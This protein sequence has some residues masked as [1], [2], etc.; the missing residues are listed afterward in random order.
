[1]STEAIV[2]VEEATLAVGDG[3]ETDTISVKDR[4]PS[5]VGLLRQR[6]RRDRF[7]RLAHLGVGDAI[8]DVGKLAVRA[9]WLA[10]SD[11]NPPRRDVVHECAGIAVAALNPMRASRAPVE[12]TIEARL[13]VSDALTGAPGRFTASSKAMFS[14]SSPRRRRWPSPRREVRG[15]TAAVL[16]AG[17]A[18]LSSDDYGAGVGSAGPREADGVG[19]LGRGDERSSR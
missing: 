15:K 17:A 1:M 10:T 13:Q 2:T 5:G 11:M 19:Q 7:H 14:L 6:L 4:S 3:D 12:R 16:D 8:L 18:P 9:A